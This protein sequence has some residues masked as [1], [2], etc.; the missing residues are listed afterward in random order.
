MFFDT[1]RFPFIRTLEEA[2]PVIRSEYESLQE[3]HFQEW[4]EKYLYEDGWKVFGLWGFG[5]R[6]DENC[7]LCPETAKTLGQIDGLFQAGFSRLKPGT[8][9]KPH[10][11]R[12]KEQLRCHLGIIIPDGC[13][14]RVEDETRGWEEGKCLLFDD[15]VEHEAWNRGDRDRIVLLIDIP[16]QG[17]RENA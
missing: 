17:A 2:Y 15:T 16:S 12:A 11:G 10:K 4:P 8:H 7:Q 14:L 6:L 1:S 5:H 3:T 13:A 9:I